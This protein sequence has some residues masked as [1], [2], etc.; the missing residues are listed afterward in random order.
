LTGEG[1]T[2]NGK[3]IA[4]NLELEGELWSQTEERFCGSRLDSPPL[5]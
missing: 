5:R 1:I 4:S 2:T 3:I